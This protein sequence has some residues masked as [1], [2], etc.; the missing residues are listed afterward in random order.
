MVLRPILASAG[1]ERSPA[2]LFS[3]AQPGIPSSPPMA[4][5]ATDN[6]PAPAKQASRPPTD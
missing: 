5:L 3:V 1:R 2:M 6:S 4:Q